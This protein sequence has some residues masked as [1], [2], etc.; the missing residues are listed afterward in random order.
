MFK[1]DFFKGEPL[2]KIGDCEFW[3]KQLITPELAKEILQ[4]NGKN[5]KLSLHRV[6]E[7]SR[8]MGGAMEKHGRRHN[9]FF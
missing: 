6:L 8:M 2:C 4:S 7:Y 1:D 5:R 3:G 9:Y